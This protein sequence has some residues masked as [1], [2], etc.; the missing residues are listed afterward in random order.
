MTTSTTTSNRSIIVLLGGG[1]A[2][3]KKTTANSLKQELSKIPSTN[4]DIEIIDMNQFK[5]GCN[6]SSID[7]TEYYNQ[8]KSAAIT[9][10]KE[11]HHDKYPSLKP[12]RFQFDKLKEVLRSKLYIPVDQPQKVLIVHG[13]YALYDKEIRDLSNIKVFIDSDSD[14]RLIRW[15]RRDVLERK[16]NTLDS[17]IN[18]Y[19]LGARREMNDFIFPTKEFA[20]VIM[21]KGANEPNDAVKLVIDGI[22]LYLTDKRPET[23][24]LP[25][26][27][28]NYLRPTDELSLEKERFDIQKNKFYELN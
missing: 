14:T 3:G 27:T 24:Y 16:T 1:H 23:M 6:A 20:D 11:F 4:V 12:S 9:V 18:A 5:E 7:T 17:V 26:T 21:P 28:S 8:G 13:L 25:T 2:A 15:I 22:I 19:L 10:S